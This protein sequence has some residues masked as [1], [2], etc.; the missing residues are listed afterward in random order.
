ML[1]HLIIIILPYYFLKVEEGGFQLLTKSILWLSVPFVKSL[2]Y[3][4]SRRPLHGWLDVLNTDS[5]AILR[6]NVS[7]FSPQELG[8][9]RI[10]YTHDDSETRSDSFEFV[11]VSPEDDDFLVNICYWIF[12]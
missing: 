2:R 10:K 7:Y 6:G 5:S 1:L 3:E 8:D 12:L 9:K 4:L 11:A